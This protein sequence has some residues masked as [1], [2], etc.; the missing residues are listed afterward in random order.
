KENGEYNDDDDG[1]GFH[2]TAIAIVQSIAIFILAG[3]AEIMGGWLVWATIKG[4]RDADDGGN[5]RK[6]P[7]YYALVGSLVLVAYG[8]IPCL[9]PSASTDGFGRIYAAYGGYF[10]VLSFLLAWALEG[11]VARP[12]VGDLV[13]G[14]IALVGV[15]VIMFWPGR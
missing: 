4:V 14:G 10:I 6:R 12:D 2:W 11:D 3:I 7:W 5:I 1:G 8:Y 9:Q 15:F 13:G